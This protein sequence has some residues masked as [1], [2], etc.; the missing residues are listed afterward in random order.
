MS[1]TQKPPYRR[2]QIYSLDPSLDLELEMAIVSR[3]VI[4]VP[5]EELEPGPVGEYIEVIDVDPSSECVYAP[6]D[7]DL[8]LGSDGMNPSTGNPQFHQQMV[9]AVA[10]L[11]IANFE[12]ILGRKILWAERY[13]DHKGKYISS[14]EKRFVRRFTH[15]S[16]CP[17]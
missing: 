16:P 11:T 3:A 1:N 4:N 15:L 2:L 9:Y 14:Y 6:V 12:R 13:K 10:S 5:W 17:S 7:L 8:T